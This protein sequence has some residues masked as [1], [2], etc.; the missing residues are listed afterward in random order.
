VKGTVANNFKASKAQRPELNPRASNLRF[1]PM[2]ARPLPPERVAE[3]TR[4][5]VSASEFDIFN[6]PMGTAGP[7]IFSDDL[8]CDIRSEFRELIGDG[9]SPQEATD[10]II[11]DY[12]QSGTPT[13]PDEG[14]TFWIALAATQW[15]CGRLLDSVKAKALASIAPD[16]E[17]WR[18]SADGDAKMISKLVA[19]RQAALEKFKAQMLSPQPK[20]TK[21]KKTY[22]DRTDW[23]IG[24]LVSYRLTSGRSIVLR[25]IGVEEHRKSRI[26]LCDIAQWVGEQLPSAVELTNMARWRDVRFDPVEPFD[27]EHNG[28][29]AMYSYKP[30]DFPTNRLKVIAKQQPLVATTGVGSMYFGGWAEFDRFLEEYF[31]LT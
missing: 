25:V 11:A 12:T 10:K 1:L 24:H 7:A 17:R 15:K 16:L 21:I 2:P 31:G 8:A 28:K 30:T 13:D 20:A 6:I 4:R 18:A 29:M 19:G 3:K 14:P 9:F 26:A 27:R 23:E 5:V 22:H